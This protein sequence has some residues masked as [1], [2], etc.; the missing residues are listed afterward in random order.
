[1]V[2]QVITFQYEPNAAFFQPV[3]AALRKLFAKYGNVLGCMCFVRSVSSAASSLRLPVV[4]RNRRTNM[5]R[6]P[7]LLALHA[8]YV[9]S[10]VERRLTEPYCTISAAEY[11]VQWAG[12]V[13]IQDPAHVSAAPAVG[14]ARSCTRRRSRETGRQI[15]NHCIK[16]AD[17]N[18]APSCRIL[19]RAAAARVQG[20]LRV[21]DACS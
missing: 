9:L 12:R 16:H 10:P 3:Y 7:G 5:V 14:S 19:T 8:R 15:D 2:C 17:R 4:V 1:M 6:R 20:I 11:C 21:P 13:L 18:T